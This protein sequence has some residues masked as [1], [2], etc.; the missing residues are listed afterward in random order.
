MTTSA[1]NLT[2]AYA[3]DP[4][5]GLGDPVADR[6]LGVITALAGELFTCKAELEHLRRRLV[7]ADVLVDGDDDRAGADPELAAWMK[8]EASAYS[9]HLLD[10]LAAQPGERLFR[11]GL[12]PEDARL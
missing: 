7:D 6:L 1:T 5:T 8:A 2:E 3:Y 9:K 10:P 11:F 4:A 12:S